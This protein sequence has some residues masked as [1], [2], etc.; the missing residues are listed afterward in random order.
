MGTEPTTSGLGDLHTVSTE[1]YPSM[2]CRSAWRDLGD[3]TGDVAMRQYIQHMT[4]L[5]PDWEIQVRAGP[6]C[7][8]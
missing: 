4:D 7:F 3:M 2:S 8:F 6:A 1:L 5:R